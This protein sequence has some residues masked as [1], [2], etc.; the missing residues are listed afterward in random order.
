[1]FFSRLPTEVTIYPSENY[2][3]FI[4]CIAGRQIW[5]NIRLPAGKREQGVLAFAYSEFIEFPSDPFNTLSRSK[6]FTERDGVTV[7]RKDPFT[8]LVSQRKRR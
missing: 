5:G 4:E 1:M 8:W 7:K 6:Y 2:Y 3:Y